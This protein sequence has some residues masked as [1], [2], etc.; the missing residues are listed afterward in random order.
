MSASMWSQR[1]RP[2]RGSTSKNQTSIQV[3]EYDIHAAICTENFIDADQ[4]NKKYSEYAQLEIS[5]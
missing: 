2:N 5:S 4:K 1:I 3:S